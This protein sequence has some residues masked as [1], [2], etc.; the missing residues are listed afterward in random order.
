MIEFI[1]GIID[2]MSIV[3]FVFIIF[4]YKEICNI[5]DKLNKNN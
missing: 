2:G 3:G 1:K 4:I 5:K